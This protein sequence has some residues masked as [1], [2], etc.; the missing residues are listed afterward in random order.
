M[1]DYTWASGD[2][3]ERYV[4]RWSRAV[5]VEFVRW[6]R[7]PEDM[8]WVDVGCGTGALTSAILAVGRPDRVRAYDLSTQYLAAARERVHDPRVEF[9]QSDARTLPEANDTF[10]TAV[11]GLMLNFVPDPA[12]AVTEMRRVTRP[13]GAVAVYVWDYAGGM[14]L[15]RIFWNAAV[16]LDAAAAESDEGRRF[17]LCNPAPLHDLFESAGL[18]DVD[19]RAID[20][21]TRF[22]TFDDYWQPFLGGQG[23]APGYLVSLDEERR[24]ALKVLI[25]KKLP[26]QADGSIAL[27]A[28]AWAVRGRA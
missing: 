21:P 26:Q 22:V 6:L 1:A 2:A 20:V 15:I 17:E 13:G 7:L 4:G 28:R 18:Q 23:P 24:T 27:T 8:N 3:Y 9:G 25:Q 11:S 19:V 5:A 16:E 12:R 14:Q 10:D